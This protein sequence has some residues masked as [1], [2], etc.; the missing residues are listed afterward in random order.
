MSRII[1]IGIDARERS[2]KDSSNDS[3]LSDPQVPQQGNT[4]LIYSLPSTPLSGTEERSEG[5]ESRTDPRAGLDNCFINPSTPAKATPMAG[6]L[7]SGHSLL[8]ISELGSASVEEYL[9]N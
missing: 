8:F 3:S 9:A 5:G 2:R 1:L 4:P 7:I 6:C